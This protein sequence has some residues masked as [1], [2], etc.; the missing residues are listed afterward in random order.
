[1]KIKIK[2]KGFPTAQDGYLEANKEYDLP[3]HFALYCVKKMKSAEYVTEQKK[4]IRRTGR[5]AK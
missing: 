1:M 4:Q 5:K 3:E 2:N